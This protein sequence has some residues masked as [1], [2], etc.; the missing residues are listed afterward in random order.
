MIKKLGDE[1]LNKVEGG[2]GGDIKPGTCRCDNCK[3]KIDFAHII[4]NKRYCETCYKKITRSLNTKGGV[5]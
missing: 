1:E 5:I 4:D 3:T 2:K